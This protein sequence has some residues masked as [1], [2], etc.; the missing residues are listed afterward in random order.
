MRAGGEDRA[1]AST[2]PVMGG[3]RSPPAGGM[4]AGA[5]PAVHAGGHC[6]SPQ[7]S[8]RSAEM[9]TR[10]RGPAE[11]ASVRT[12]LSARGWHAS[13]WVR[14]STATRTTARAP[15]GPVP[16]RRVPDRRAHGQQRRLRPVRRRDRL[17]DDRRAGGVVVRLRRAAARRLPAD[18][19]GGRGAV[20]APGPR[21]HLAAP[22][23]AGVRPRRPVRPSGR[24]RVVDRRTG[25][26]PLGR[27][28]A[29]VGGRVGVRRSR[30]SRAAPVSRGAT[31]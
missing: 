14:T 26:L 22:R 30:R 15:R 6:C 4:S 9:A 18:A 19:G 21:R 25:V 28:P 10:H 7:R 29:A 20:V 8:T 11:T 31:N 24:A 1:A 16:R 17:R 5:A 3:P 12:D 27:R 2:S 23:G 13:G